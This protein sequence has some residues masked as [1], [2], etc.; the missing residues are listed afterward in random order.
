[1]PADSA[2]TAPAGGSGSL[3]ESTGRAARAIASMVC[4]SKN[5]R[6]LSS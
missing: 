6:T 4:S 3:P 2:A 1:M 5:S